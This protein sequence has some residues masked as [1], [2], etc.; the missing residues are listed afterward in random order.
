MKAL[1]II[2]DCG[3][4]PAGGPLG[5]DLIRGSLLGIMGTILTSLTKCKQMYVVSVQVRVDIIQNEAIFNVTVI[6]S[7]VMH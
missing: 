6:T 3:Q 4:C 5:A 2:P 1:R 7:T